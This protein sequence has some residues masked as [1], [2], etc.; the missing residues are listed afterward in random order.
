[1]AAA[2]ASIS[3]FWILFASLVWRWITTSLSYFWNL[4]PIFVD[5]LYWHHWSI[6]LIFPL[7]LVLGRC[8]TLFTTL[9]GR[10]WVLSTY[11]IFLALTRCLL[12]S[13]AP[14]IFRIIL[15]LGRWWVLSMVLLTSPV[16]QLAG[17]CPLLFMALPGRYS[18]ML[19]SW[20][21][22]CL[23]MVSIK[24]MTRRCPIHSMPLIILVLRR[25]SVLSMV[26]LISSLIF[27]SR[28]CLISTTVQL[29]SLIIPTL[30]RCLIPY[31]ILIFF[32]AGSYMILR[33]KWCG[34]MNW[35]FST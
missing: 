24:L 19:T 12:S 2:L 13:T 18:L 16:N 26:P 33:A 30:W 6:S 10:W 11:W 20:L 32:M 29:V 4:L 27:P 5:V 15:A 21:G 34:C 22:R 7:F 8:L 23:L 9:L 35:C 17:K 28:R 1:M 14:L 25:C 3:M 31:V